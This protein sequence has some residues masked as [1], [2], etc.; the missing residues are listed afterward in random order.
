[1]KI[2]FMGSP[3][4]AVSSLKAIIDAG[5]EVLA[6]VTA[7]DKIGGRGHNQLI[8]TDVKK[9]ALTN[10]LPILQPTNLKNPE[11]VASLQG[12]NADL[13]VVVAFRMLPEVVW[14]IPP[15]GTI[16]IHGSLL[17]KYRGA[18][19]INWAIIQGEKETGVTSFLI[20]KDIDTGPILL[21]SKTNISE[22]D[23]FGIVYNKLKILGAELLLKT[24]AMLENDEIK[25]LV[26]V[27]TQVTHAPKIYR[28]T[29]QI[30]A[31]KSSQEVHNFVRGLAPY[32]GAWLEW[33]G[34]EYKI[35]K[36]KLGEMG[37]GTLVAK[38]CFFANGRHLYLQCA[39]GFLEI[40]EL[41]PEG[42]RKMLAADFIN[43]FRN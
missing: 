24:L 31:S 37:Q 13:F 28:E 34:V 15:K 26:Q 38:A 39:D 22:D 16:N 18:A 43:G 5:V 17:P 25:P 33:Q 10:N 2:V 21:Q 29:C 11:F 3:D 32:P 40:L 7:A 35:L 14:S 6:V 36:S 20:R 42:K 19:P 1:M 41:Q 4:F 30:D 9:F 8:S 23:D 27:E 12:L